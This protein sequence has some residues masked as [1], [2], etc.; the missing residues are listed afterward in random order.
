MFCSVCGNNYDESAAFCPI[1]GAA[2]NSVAA[3]AVEE[4]PVDEPTIGGFDSIPPVAPQ[5][6][7]TAIPEAPVAAPV[8]VAIPEAPVVA[9]VEVAIPEAPVFAPVEP[10]AP[11]APQPEFAPV[12]PVAQPAAPVEAP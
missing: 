9:P 10:V 6:V 1:C 8:E 2:N 7:E 4:A 11:V 3:P 5:P 12:A